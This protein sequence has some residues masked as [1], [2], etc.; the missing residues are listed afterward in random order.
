MK[1]AIVTP[2]Y[3]PGLYLLEA[4]QSVLSQAGDISI[5]YHVQDAN[6][7]DGTEAFLN[8][9]SNQIA[10]GCA[11][12]QCRNISFSYISESDE[13]MYDGINRGLKILL[14]RVQ[15][16]I[17]LWINSDDRLADKA[18]CNLKNYFEANPK[19]SWVTG[20][21]VHLDE[22]S[23]VTLDIPPIKY[24]VEDLAMGRHNGRDMP[25]VTQ[26]ATAWRYEAFVKAG[27]LDAR[28]RYIGDYLYWIALSSSGIDLHSVDFEVGHHRK[29][30]GQ[31]SESPSYQYEISIFKNYS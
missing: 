6:S 25:F 20:R 3:N 16:D 15:P 12:V 30:K 31:L 7:T 8:S 2:C 18:L 27:F 1:F 11:P 28:F 24:R 17:I 14:K 22:N 29:R 9:I 4:L 26:E 23:S 19:V 13:G 5:Y 10:Q 21:T